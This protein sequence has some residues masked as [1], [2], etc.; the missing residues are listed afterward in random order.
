MADQKSERLRAHPAERF[1]EP[2]RLFDLQAVAEKLKHEPEAGEAGRRQETLYR[3]GR[4][5]VALFVFDRLTRLAQHRAG[6]VVQI[7]VLKGHLRVTADGT[8]HDLPA[9]SLLVLAAGVEH[10]VVAQQESHML[11]TIHLDAVAPTK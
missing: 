9:G 1:A 11:L 7:Q 4:M 5:S 6:G 8:P 3:H 2:Q 10:D